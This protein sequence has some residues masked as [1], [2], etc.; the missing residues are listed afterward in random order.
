[1]PSSVYVSVTGTL[2]TSF[3]KLLP[4]PSSS[5]NARVPLLKYTLATVSP[6]FCVGSHMS[7]AMTCTCAHRNTVHVL[8][9]VELKTPQFV[10]VG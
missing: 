3:D 6:E 7:M 10:Y 8:G 5:V 2:V 1:M 4:H 9:D